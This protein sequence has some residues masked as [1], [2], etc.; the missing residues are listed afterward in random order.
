LTRPDAPV[1]VIMPER[2]FAPAF[3][4]DDWANTQQFARKIH[5]SPGQILLESHYENR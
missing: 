1:A 5:F 2:T 4:V 3:F